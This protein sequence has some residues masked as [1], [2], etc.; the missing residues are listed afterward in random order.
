MIDLIKLND[1]SLGRRYSSETRT[2]RALGRRKAESPD[3]E[4]AGQTVQRKSKQAT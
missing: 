2:E 3:T 4:E 1:Q